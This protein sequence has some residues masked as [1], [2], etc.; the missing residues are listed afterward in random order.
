MNKQEFLAMSLPHELKFMLVADIR[1][2][3][4]DEPI[5]TT[6]A[7][8]ELI[9]VNI[10]KDLYISV[11]EG[12][13]G[14]LYRNGNNWLSIESGLKPILHPLSDLTKPIEHKGEKF[15]PILKLA[16]YPAMEL[17]GVGYEKKSY[18]AGFKYGEDIIRFTIPSDAN[19]MD[20][21]TVQKLI[22][23]HFDV[24]DLISKNE[25]IDVNT[26]ETN[27]YK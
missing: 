22:E 5:Y 18:Y 24:A 27:P 2:D 1:D 14:D 10:L 9:G 25:A 17:M 26:L 7:I 16:L 20:F 6:G 12:D 23:W 13:L 4:E 19:S 15:V 11:G 8:W 21:F 3:F